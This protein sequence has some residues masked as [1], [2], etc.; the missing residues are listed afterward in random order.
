MV[1]KPLNCWQRRVTVTTVL[2][3]LWT[4]PQTSSYVS[5]NSLALHNYVVGKGVIATYVVL[6]IEMWSKNLKQCIVHLKPSID[7]SVSCSHCDVSVHSLIHTHTRVYHCMQHE[8]QLYVLFIA[9]CA[10]QRSC[11]K[12][13]TFP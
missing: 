4:C 13:G 6:V 3:C 5:C 8:L 9:Q 10:Y 7:S 12:E 2:P 11:T 1:Q